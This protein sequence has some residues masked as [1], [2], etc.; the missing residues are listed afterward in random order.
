MKTRLFKVMMALSAIALA[1]MACGLGL[2]GVTDGPANLPPTPI[3]G[4]DSGGSGSGDSG[5]S[6]NNGN[7]PPPPPSGDR[8]LLNDDFRGPDSRWGT[9]TDSDS[10]VE[11]VDDALKFDIFSTNLIVYSGPNDTDYSNVHIEVTAVNSS[12]DPDAGFGILCNQQFM[13]DEFY[14]VYITSRGDY[15]IVK[16]MFVE[17]NII[18]ASGFSELIPQNAPSYQI[19]VDCRSD[20]TI[21]L[22]VNGQL[23][24]SITDSAT[25][26][27]YSSGHVGLLAFTIDIASG[28]T[29]SFDDFIITELK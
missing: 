1:A 28:A 7:V 23:I 18:L 24:D 10:A 8:P 9:G 17:D 19:G 6:N 4:G 25:D 12:A 16:S 3:V 20:G 14:Y 2:P 13:D 21:T 29:V 5:G 26:S 27:L 22:Y 15:G 11:Y